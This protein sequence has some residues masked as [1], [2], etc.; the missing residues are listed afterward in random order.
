MVKII[1]DMDKATHVIIQGVEYERFK[2][3]EGGNPDGKAIAIGLPCKVNVTPAT[4]KSKEFKYWAKVGSSFGGKPI[5]DN[6]LRVDFYPKP[7]GTTSST[8]TAFAG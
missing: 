5:K 6:C 4:A 8:E 2:I 3:A 1:A 7:I